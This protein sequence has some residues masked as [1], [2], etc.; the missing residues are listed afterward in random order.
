MTFQDVADHSTIAMAAG[1]GKA[2]NIKLGLKTLD[3][4]I[5]YQDFVLTVKNVGTF[6]PKRQDEQFFF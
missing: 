5:S 1:G 3:G 6:I 2:M 4:S